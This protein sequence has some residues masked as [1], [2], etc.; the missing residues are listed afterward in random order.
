M[1][2]EQTLAALPLAQNCSEDKRARLMSV[3]HSKGKRDH[4]VLR[5]LYQ[6]LHIKLSQSETLKLVF[7]FQKKSQKIT[8]EKP[9]TRNPK[10]G[11]IGAS[12]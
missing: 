12:V 3:Q 8:K 5:I 9:T 11:E 10:P 7:F 6:S 2:N 4:D 1:G